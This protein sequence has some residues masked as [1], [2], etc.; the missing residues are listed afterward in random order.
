MV[1]SLRLRIG[2]EVE[3]RRIVGGVDIPRFMVD[4][5]G[6]VGSKFGSE[7]AIGIDV[8]G[9]SFLIQEVVLSTLD[10]EAA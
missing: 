7:S 5:C 6:I 9:I 3:Y 2:C 4:E 8:G 1:L 10:I